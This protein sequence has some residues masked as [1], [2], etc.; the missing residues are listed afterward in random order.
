MSDGRL[1]LW[2]CGGGRQ[3]AGIAAL[4]AM[5]KLPRP[6]HVAM[7][8]I[9]WEIETVWP[10]VNRY[11]RPAMEAA[12]VPFTEIAR[13]EYAKRDFWG[14]ADGDSILL[15]VYSDQSGKKSKLPEYCSGEWK[16]DVL[17]RWAAAQPGWKDRGVDNWIGIS[18]D[19]Q[20]RRRGPR[21]KWIQPVYPLLDILPTRVADCLAAVEAMG[22][23]PPPRSRCEHCPNQAD[24]EWA[25]LSPEAFERVA[26]REDAIRKIDP[27]AYFHKSLVPLRVAVLNPKTDEPG[28]FGGC[29]AGMCL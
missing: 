4:I 15:P 14:G 24:A 10:Y 8:R 6:D 28:L 17:M 11:I 5:G 21:R 7:V 13:S 2:S 18:L 25:E 19:E 29:T 1:Q 20:S 16:R 23:P 27:H 3:S 12:G 22:W 9:E 26:A